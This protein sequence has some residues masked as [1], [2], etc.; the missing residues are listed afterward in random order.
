MLLVPRG[1]RPGVLLNKH[2]QSTRQPST[3]K[4]SLN[5]KVE[6]VKVRELH[7]LNPC[8]Q[9]LSSANP[10][11]FLLLLC[12][13]YRKN[14]QYTGLLLLKVIFAYALTVLYSCY[15]KYGPWTE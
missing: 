10:L 1:S 15:S 5:P 4:N 2:Y 13:W 8:C 12:A 9:T 7:S 6:L 11:I 3:P 14:I